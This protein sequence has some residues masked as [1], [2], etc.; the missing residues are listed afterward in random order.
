[1]MTKFRKVINEPIEIDEDGV[2]VGGGINAVVSANV[3]EKGSPHVSSK[4]RVKV[5]QRAGRTEVLEHESETEETEG[6]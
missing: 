1:M 3:N 2:T 4:Q 6:S 5:V